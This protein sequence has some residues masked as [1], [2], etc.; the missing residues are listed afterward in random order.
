M[1]TNRELWLM[2]S[3]YLE[4]HECG[5]MQYQPKFEAWLNMD[6]ADGVTVSEVLE[7]DAP[8]TKEDS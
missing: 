1:L 5:S 6:A 8:L 2:E 4:G 7:K 3:A